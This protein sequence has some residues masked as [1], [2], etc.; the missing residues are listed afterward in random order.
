MWFGRK[1]RELTLCTPPINQSDSS[2]VEAGRIL[3]KVSPCDEGE[4]VVC[5]EYDQCLLAE[6]C[7]SANETLRWA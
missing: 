2:L 4:T 1:E 6:E 7:L 5:I 3:A